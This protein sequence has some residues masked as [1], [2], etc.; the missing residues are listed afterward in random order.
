[1][2]TMISVFDLFLGLI[3]TI[4]VLALQGLFV[5]LGISVGLLMMTISSV[6]DLLDRKSP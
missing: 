2:I 1:M 5:V 3:S 6:L 4:F